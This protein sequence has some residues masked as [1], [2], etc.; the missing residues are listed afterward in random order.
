VRDA[1]ERGKH[2][3]L[4]RRGRPLDHGRWLVLGPSV[5]HKLLGNVVEVLDGHQEHQRAAGLRQRSPIVR[6]R[7]VAGGDGHRRAQPA[8]GDR[9][10]CRGRRRECRAD[11]WHDLEGDPGLR[12]RERLFAAAPEHERV[13]AL[14]AHH[15]LPAVCQLHQQPFD[16]A[17]GRGRAA[18]RLAHV[19]QPRGRRREREHPRADQSI[20][21]DRVGRQNAL[22]RLER[23]QLGVAWPGPDQRDEA[24]PDRV[25]AVDRA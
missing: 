25:G 19:V 2:R 5:R 20:V 15:P 4:A 9:D 1:A 22:E 17:L 11:A 18:D 14:Q 13:A 3:L 6:A 21:H 16:V 10:T 23:E 24:T 8:M 12:Q 7:A